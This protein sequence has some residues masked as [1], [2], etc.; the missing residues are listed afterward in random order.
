MTP[1][2]RGPTSGVRD[3]AAT[4]PPGSVWLGPPAPNERIVC[5]LR[6]R[7]GRTS[8]DT[9]G[10][11]ELDV[12]WEFAAQAGL[13]VIDLDL[14]DRM[15]VL[16]GPAQNVSEAFGV[17]L[18][19]YKYGGKVR[20]GHVGSVSIPPAL[21]AL[22]E[23]FCGVDDPAPSI[24]GSP[25]VGQA[26]VSSLTRPHVV[27]AA[28]VLLAGIG[29]GTLLFGN[30]SSVS[31]A[32]RAAAPLQVTAPAHAPRV[33]SPVQ[34]LE[35][36][37]RAALR[38][39]RLSE[40]QDDFLRALALDE[41]SVA[42]MDGLVAVRRKMSADNAQLIRRQLAIYED[43]IAQGTTTGEYYTPSSLRF[44]VAANRRA[45]VDIEGPGALRVPAA[46]SAGQAAVPVTAA[47]TLAAPAKPAPHPPVPPAPPIAPR[48]DPRPSAHVATPPPV[49]QARPAGQPVAI[50][51]K[52]VSA[53]RSPVVPAERPVQDRP[54]VPAAPQTPVLPRTAPTAGATPAP[55]PQAAS[56]AAPAPEPSAAAPPQLVTM[57]IGPFTDRDRATAIGARLS[58]AGFSQ[59]RVDTMK[60]YWVVSEPLPRTEAERLVSALAGRG[61][62]PYVSP[63]TG[64]TVQLI[65]G[66]FASQQG[67]DALTSRVAAAGYDA[68]LREGTVYLVHLGPYPLAAVKNITDIVR[69]TAPEATIAGDPVP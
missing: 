51:P 42:A 49:A 48:T 46:P 36:A 14:P 63:A 55:S 1:A 10:W 59:A 47:V 26:W 57:R 7:E 61:F 54:V 23:E 15:V 40:A 52:T 69:G 13:D 24:Q 28:L 56:P 11:S 44:L 25:A 65:F 45:L 58:A 5:A 19:R 33:V 41:R 37:G 4:V 53:A 12:L 62:H 6:L 8:E 30:H 2:E 17:Q 34:G 29:L 50:P 20:S 35:A 22:V 27:V 60:G 64:N 68:W 38:S 39:G 32:R 16:G 21:A 43:A 67:A 18:V 31:S 3:G 66:A 9:D